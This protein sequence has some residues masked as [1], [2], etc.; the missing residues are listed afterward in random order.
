ME[1]DRP[2]ALGD[3]RRILHVDQ[4]E[5]PLLAPRLHVAS[6]QQV[7]QRAEAHPVA[8][9]ENHVGKHDHGDRKREGVPEYLVELKGVP[10]DCQAR[11]RQADEDDGR[12][13][14]NPEREVKPQRL[15]AQAADEGDVLS[16]DLEQQDRR[17]DAE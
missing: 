3:A 11:H 10:N 13:H 2:Q 14:G 8:D 1:A 7:A 16:L 9:L 5:R 12:V 6:G 17:G 4:Q 15:A